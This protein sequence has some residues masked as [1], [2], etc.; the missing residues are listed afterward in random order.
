MT[1]FW[2]IT[3][4]N[5]FFCDRQHEPHDM[6]TTTEPTPVKADGRIPV[7]ANQKVWLAAGKTHVPDDDDLVYLTPEELANA[8]IFAMDASTYSVMKEQ[9]S[10][11]GGRLIRWHDGNWSWIDGTKETR[12]KS[13][14]LKANYPD[15][16]TNSFESCVEVPVL[17]AAAWDD[18][19]WVVDANYPKKT[20]FT[21]PNYWNNDYSPGPF[22]RSFLPGEPSPEV[23]EVPTK[24]WETHCQSCLG[25]TWN[26]SDEHEIIKK[27]EEL[28][29]EDGQPI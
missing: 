11:F 4:L 9:R 19:K 25:V 5:S 13:R 1:K 27:A 20:G 3:K 26:P 23:Y 2:A 24:D 8:Q 7:K 29:W 14:T 18:L 22:G 6:T 10:F 28:G 15:I 16:A 21:D 12:V 17:L